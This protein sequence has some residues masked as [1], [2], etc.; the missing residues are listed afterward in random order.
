MRKSKTVEMSKETRATLTIL[1]KEIRDCKNLD[2]V[3][4]LL[5][6]WIMGSD[7]HLEEVKSF[8]NADELNTYLESI[9]APYRIK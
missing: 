6:T 1:I 7:L 9:N 3:N 4:R 2:E 5:D 8:R